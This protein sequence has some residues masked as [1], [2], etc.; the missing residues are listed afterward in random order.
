MNGIWQ[1]Y[2]GELI[3]DKVDRVKRQDPKFMVLWI[4]VVTDY[5]TTVLKP[6]HTFEEYSDFLN[7][8]NYTPIEEV[9]SIRI[10]M[11]EGLD[12]H[13][14]ILGFLTD[15]DNMPDWKEIDTR[16]PSDD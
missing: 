16:P 11:T 15:Y 3:E 14:G 7:E 13:F 1:D 2:I 6:N 9:Q 4:E 10:M 8:F 5:E 12:C